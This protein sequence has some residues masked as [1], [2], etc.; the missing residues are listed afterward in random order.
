[1]ELVFD[2]ND[3]EE[4]TSDDL[5]TTSIP[6]L[7]PDLLLKCIKYL[8]VSSL[9]AVAQACR[10]LKVIVYSDELWESKLLAIGFGFGSGKRASKKN[11]PNGTSLL[12]EPN[13]SL[14][15]FP[16][17][18]SS[19]SDVAR[20]RISANTK[21]V[22]SSTKSNTINNNRVSLSNLSE[23]GFRSSAELPTPTITKPRI[24]IPGL[25]GDPYSMIEGR[26]VYHGAREQFRQIYCE[27][28]PYYID[29][30]QANKD[31][32][33]IQEFGKSV[34]DVARMLARL[35]AF[36]KAYLAEDSDQI[37]ENLHGTCEY[38]ENRCLHLFELAYDSRDIPEMAKFAGVL[39]DLN[40]AQA[41]IQIFIQKNGIFFDNN[42]E[43]SENLKQYELWL[44]QPLVLRESTPFPE[45]TPMKLFMEFTEMEFK[46]QAVIINDVFPEEAD[47][48]FN[49]TERVFEDVISDYCSQLFDMCSMRD[50]LLYLK[51]VP[52]AYRYL[53]H[54]ENTI[55][56]MEP[57]HVSSYRLEKLLAR[58][59]GP[60][61]EQY[62]KMELDWVQKSCKDQIDKHDR[63]R[64]DNKKNDTKRMNPRNRE[65]FK[66]N[67]LKGFR[68]VLTLP[69]KISSSIVAGVA[70]ATSSPTPTA[71]SA[72]STPQLHPSSPSNASPSNSSTAPTKG[73]NRFS[74]RSI[75]SLS[76]SSNSGSTVV[77]PTSTST[78][79]IP[80]LSSSTFVPDQKSISLGSDADSV[81]ST[82]GGVEQIVTA[83]EIQEEMNSLLSVELAL[84]LIHL[85]KDALQRLSAFAG[86]GG[87]LGGRVQK[88]IESVFIALLRSLGQQHIDPGFTA[89][90]QQLGRYKPTT[91]HGGG[92]TP[93]M[94]FF[95]LVH[96]AD[97]ILQMVQVY[98][99]EEMCKHIDKMDFLNDANKEKKAFERLIDDGV[100]A[101]LD[102]S[103][104]VL[105]GQVE[106][107]LTTMQLP[108][109]YN[110]DESMEIELQP[111]Q[112]CREAV[113]CLT[114]HTKMLI[115]CT[116]KHT[117]DVF[118][119]ELGLR[120]FNCLT[121][122]LR[123]NIVSS[124]GGFVLICDL[125]HY[126]NFIVTLKQPM[127]TP[128]F[129]ALKELGN[130]FIIQSP[131]DL[132]QLI[133]DMQRFG[134]I[135][136]V[137]DVFEFA[138]MRSDWKSIQR[139]VER[140]RL[141]CAIM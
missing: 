55:V 56:R 57:I 129:L 124:Q 67:F 59:F 49:F 134:G 123:S 119:Q 39:L 52:T 53:E 41:C 96:V 104:E 113:T 64:E 87:V 29:F 70:S 72:P 65:V 78:P 122:H 132:K 45:F 75:S 111:T 77:P 58:I 125:N 141:E 116:D 69:Y 20:K 17:H 8:P 82:S 89:A 105:I 112:A 33:V 102:K 84:H 73:N 107:I 63:Q 71:G 131:S 15:S 34:L 47:V 11:D 94:D 133:H 79:D 44:M 140:D 42:Y 13:G 16:V 91:T 27:L 24:Q 130:L 4:G 139:I 90:I 76:G 38:F 6:I 12:D 101:G 121:K 62:L 127:L 106:Y 48:L 46:K 10:R 126:Y 117:L 135:L 115:G 128:N 99:A 51:S 93:L 110:P 88:T 1:M 138:E 2:V 35:L 19:I 50:K 25:P 32:K 118:F 14:P 137:E 22:I 95:E 85:D 60:W 7:P 103:I 36:S 31:S 66:R 40:D 100:A 136:R 86:L 81:R 54:L 61:L 9:P 98:Y 26:R 21:E 80:T 23:D 30:R 18:G 92:V 83:Q 37:N 109:D 5:V 108:T 120:L 43:P 3:F 74:I 97:L 28:W 68:N 114:T